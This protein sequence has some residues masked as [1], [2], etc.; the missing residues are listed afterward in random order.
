MIMVD[1]L[2]MTGQPDSW[3]AHDIIGI[4]PKGSFCEDVKITNVDVATG[5]QT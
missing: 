2:M 3:T 4:L 1:I 5:F